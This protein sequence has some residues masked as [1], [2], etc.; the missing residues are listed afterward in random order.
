MTGQ[1]FGEQVRQVLI[2][3]DEVLQAC[4]TASSH[5][6][7]VRAYI[8]D[9]GNWPAFDRVYGTWIGAARPARCVVPVPELHYGLSLEIEA[10][11]VLRT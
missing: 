1:P 8:T 3:L 5:L 2:N 6:V 11:A 4:G 10:V 9:I 7:Q